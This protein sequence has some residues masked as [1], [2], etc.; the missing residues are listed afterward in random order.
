MATPRVWQLLLTRM[1]QRRISGSST[2]AIRR[3]ATPYVFGLPPSPHRPRPRRASSSSS[4][5]LDVHPQGTL[6]A[7]SSPA[8][9]ESGTSPC[10]E[11]MTNGATKHGA[12]LF[13]VA[14]GTGNRGRSADRDGV[15]LDAAVALGRGRRSPLPVV[16]RPIYAAAT[17]PF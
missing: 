3:V 13:Q 4:S 16:L 11:E 10:T 7:S 17:P 1:A 8:G 12:A 6:S 15:D 5:A 9:R 2:V 14:A